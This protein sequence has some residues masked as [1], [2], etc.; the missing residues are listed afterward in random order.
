MDQQLGDLS[1][2]VTPD[3]VGMKVNIEG[4]RIHE[5]RYL[6]FNDDLEAVGTFIDLPIVAALVTLTDLT[7]WVVCWW[8]TF[9]QSIS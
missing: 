6:D 2:D 9:L 4:V 8:W 3:E 7:I 5:L 1:F